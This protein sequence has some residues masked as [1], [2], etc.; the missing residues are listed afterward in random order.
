M[1]DQ[2]LEAYYNQLKSSAPRGR[3][4]ALGYMGSRKAITA[5]DDP[6]DTDTTQATELGKVRVNARGGCSCHYLECIHA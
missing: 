2:K 3:Q 6:L 1:E 4:G 5:G